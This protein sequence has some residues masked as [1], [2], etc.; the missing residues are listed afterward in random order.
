MPLTSGLL[1]PL[2]SHAQHQNNSDGDDGDGDGDDDMGEE[3][4]FIKKFFFFKN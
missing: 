2:H 3:E 1:G 4:R